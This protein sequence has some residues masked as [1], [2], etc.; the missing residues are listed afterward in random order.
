[1]SVSHSNHAAPAV[2]FCSGAHLGIADVLKMSCKFF[3]TV[4]SASVYSEDTDTCAEGTICRCLQ[5]G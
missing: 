3:G 4:V 5:S 1:M 2:F